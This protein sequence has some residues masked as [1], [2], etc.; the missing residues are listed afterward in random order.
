M[1]NNFS[2]KLH[3]EQFVPVNSFIETI[4]L[5]GSEV[6]RVTKDPKIVEVDEPTFA[7][8]ENLAFKNGIIELKVL[9]RLLPD[10]PDYARG[11]IGIAFR[12]DENNSKFEGIYIR[13][14][15]G[16]NENQSRRNSSTQYFSYPDYKF[17]R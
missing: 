14:T 7:R 9:S 4:N 2:V 15:N 17:N 16:R 12:I 11:F 5:D 10:A 13:P 6:L 8:L 3:T 1:Q